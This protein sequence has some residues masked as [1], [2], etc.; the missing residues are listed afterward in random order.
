M[1]KFYISNPKKVNGG[2]RYELWLKWTFIEGWEKLIN[3]IGDKNPV[4]VCYLFDYDGIF[5]TTKTFSGY[6]SNEYTFKA[7]DFKISNLDGSRTVLTGMKPSDAPQDSRQ[8]IQ[9][10]YNLVS[11]T[12]INT[13]KV[14]FVVET[15]GSPGLPVGFSKM[16]FPIGLFIK[17]FIV[18]MLWINRRSIF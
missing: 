2:V 5:K 10:I 16:T 17:L 15:A 11:A 6:F 4:R 7:P 18:L 1:S 14:P 13:D 12:M 8:A 3:S 9:G